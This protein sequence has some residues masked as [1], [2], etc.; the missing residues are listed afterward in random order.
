M[1]NKREK[2]SDFT[3]IQSEKVINCSDTRNISWEVKQ[4]KRN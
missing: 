4:G 1:I 3:K 2:N